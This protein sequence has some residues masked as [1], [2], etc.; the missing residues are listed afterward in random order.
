MS[1][2]PS[3]LRL[4]G[5]VGGTNVRFAIAETGGGAPLVTN[6]ESYRVADFGG[7][8]EAIEHYL[9]RM[10]RGPRPRAAVVAVAAPVT[11]GTAHLTNALWR[12][13]VSGLHQA[14]FASAALI[15][16]YT[17]LTLAV[18]RLGPDQ[19]AVIGDPKPA[20]PDKT[21][22][23]MGAG[24]GLGVAALVRDNGR[25]AIT[26]TEG[27]HI[28]FSPA[29]SVEIEILRLLQAEFGRVSLERLLSG[30]G[31]VS[32][33]GALAQLAGKTVEPIAPEVIVAR[34]MDGTDPLCA[35]TLD[36]FCAIYGGAAGDIALV[37]GALGGVYL[38]GGIA[39]RILKWLNKGAFRD[40][41]EAKG[42][43]AGYLSGIG[44]QVIMHP[45]AALLGAADAP[46]EQA[47]EA[48]HTP[49]T[50]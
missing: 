46:L 11:D 31:M 35:E 6:A 22:A 8:E 21:I 17:A 40:R 44:V 9:T 12:M 23:V 36:R 37:Y 27:G 19:L 15:N 29:D 32:L 50:V 16:D 43:F 25:E 18:R 7:L 33:R 45:F 24:T 20:R 2:S 34:A 38:G 5:D 39:P 13:S 48:P 41:F 30:P 49:E 1:P 14:G 10:H 28:G 4:V 42:R 3:N 26:V 47:S